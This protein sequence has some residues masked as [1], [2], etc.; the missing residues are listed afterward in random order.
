MIVDIAYTI[1]GAVLFWGVISF[2]IWAADKKM[3]R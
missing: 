1:F 2:C 3:K